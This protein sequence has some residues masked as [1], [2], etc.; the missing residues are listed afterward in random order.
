MLFHDGEILI[1]RFVTVS[2]AIVDKHQG[3]VGAYSKGEGFGS[4]FYFEI[5]VQRL[6]KM[7]GNTTP[8]VSIKAENV[9]IEVNHEVNVPDNSLPP[10]I[11]EGMITN[12]DVNSS[13]QWKGL[14]P[15]DS[16]ENNTIPKGD[17]DGNLVIKPSITEVEDKESISG[18]STASSDVSIAQTPS[19]PTLAPVIIDFETNGIERIRSQNL[20]ILLAD[21]SVLARK[22]VEKLIINSQLVTSNNSIKHANN[23]NEAVARIKQSLNSTE[24]VN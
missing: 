19:P 13:E 6:K 20:F 14:S 15:I 1:S 5:P 23:G 22:M 9:D 17:I 11:S 2:K 16:T 4:T 3:T 10:T 21:D 24:Q 8:K 18:K 12:I 7:S